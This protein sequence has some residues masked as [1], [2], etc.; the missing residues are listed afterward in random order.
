MENRHSTPAGYRLGLAGL[1][2]LFG[3]GIF[4]AGRF[5]E[6]GGGWGWVILVGGTLALT[7]AGFSPT[8][9][10]A[11][12]R[13]GAGFAREAEDEAGGIRLSEAVGRNFWLMGVTAAAVLFVTNM[14]QAVGGLSDFTA[15]LAGS[16]QPALAGLVL[17]LLGGLPAL[18][19][20]LAA[21]RSGEHGPA[22]AP[23]GRRWR[24]GAG[25]GLLLGA[26][27]L[28][29]AALAS[30]RQSTV[31]IIPVADLFFHPTALFLVV[32][33]GVVLAV[34]LRPAGWGAALTLAAAASGLIGAG[35]G[36]LRVVL[37]ISHADIREVGEAIAILLSSSCLSLG[38]LAAGAPLF[39]RER[40]RA[41][42]HRVPVLIRLC[43]YAYPPVVLLSLILAFIFVITPFQ[44]PA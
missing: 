41:G 15:R 30:L 7:G 21:D 10:G 19:R 2:A 36:L 8:Q 9:I 33:G 42:G 25:L 39:D 43:W 24:L 40:A 13:R 3:V 28:V 26:V 27:V 18:N 20:H 29:G 16:L 17:G 11:A 6:F 14:V 35:S 22:S 23:A 5:A 32:G 38:L 34:F 37:A 44:K 12:L 31:R 1:A 4:F